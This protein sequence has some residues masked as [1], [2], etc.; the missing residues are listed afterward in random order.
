[1]AKRLTDTEKWKDDWYISLSNDDRIVW[2][3]FLDNCSHAGFCKR[4][5]ALLNLMCRVNYSEQV[6]VAKMEERVLAVGNDW[7]IPKFIKFQYSTLFSQKPVIV[8]VVRELFQKNCIG[9][10]PE[11]FGNDYLIKEKSFDNHC[12]MIK[13][14]DKDKDK[15]KYNKGVGNKKMRGVQLN[16]EHVIFED[17]SKQALGPQQMDEHRNGRLKPKDVFKNSSY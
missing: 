11:S 8:S 13:D 2:Q 14:K 17:G 5:M 7:F 1:M 6:M 12:Q 3:W 16:G 10:I 9:I 4:S 15:D